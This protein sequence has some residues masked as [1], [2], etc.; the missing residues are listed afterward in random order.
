MRSVLSS[1]AERRYLPEGWKTSART[2]LS[3]PIWPPSP[4]FHQFGAKKKGDERTDEGFETLAGRAVPQPDRLVSRPRR[5]KRMARQSRFSP[6][7][8]RLFDRNGNYQHR[9]SAREEGERRTAIPA[10]SLSAAC[11]ETGA[12]VATS[13]TWSCP[14]S[15]TFDSPVAKSHILAV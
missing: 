1:E 15:S 6:C 14:L 4:R 5:H 2:Q 11:A 12:N 13:T 3:C 8:R 9:L 10:S 7:S